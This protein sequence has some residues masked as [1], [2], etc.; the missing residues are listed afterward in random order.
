MHVHHFIVDLF[1]LFQLTRLIVFIKEHHNVCQPQRPK[2][3]SKIDAFSLISF[4]IFLL[5]R[6]IATGTS[7]GQTY[8]VN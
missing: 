5:Q 6:R 3:H 8:T 4:V 1:Q 2:G 7:D